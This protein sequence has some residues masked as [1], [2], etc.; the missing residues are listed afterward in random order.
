M[1]FRKHRH[2][3]QILVGKRISESG[4][5]WGCFNSLYQLSEMSLFLGWSCALITTGTLWMSAS[6]V[7]STKLSTS[8]FGTWRM[9]NEEW[10]IKFL[11]QGRTSEQHGIE[12]GRPICYI[13]WFSEGSR[14][15]C[16]SLF[17][18]L[19]SREKGELLDC[20][21]RRRACSSK[22]GWNLSPRYIG[23]LLMSDISR[24]S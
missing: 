18:V 24:W 1:N 19:C 11:I 10:R 3:F 4:S 9:K 12:S 14:I 13:T 20:C 8:W 2:A 23:T 21:R 7:L 6:E 16:I 17:L 22:H 5:G 15:F